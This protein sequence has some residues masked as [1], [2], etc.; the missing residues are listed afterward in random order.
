MMFFLKDHMNKNFI[1]VISLNNN[2]FENYVIVMIK[3][4]FLDYINLNLIKEDDIN[5][6]LKNLTNNKDYE[7]EYMI[8]GEIIKIVTTIEFDNNSF[9]YKENIINN[10]NKYSNTVYNQ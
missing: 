9:D 1:D 5:E 2:E 8:N 7:I 4:V 6:V 10:R 3:D